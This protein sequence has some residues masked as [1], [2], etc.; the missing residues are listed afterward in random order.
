MDMY[1]SQTRG[2]MLATERLVANLLCDVNM[3]LRALYEADRVSCDARAVNDVDR[4]T[5]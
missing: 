2:Y 1:E 3:L 4:L 5:A